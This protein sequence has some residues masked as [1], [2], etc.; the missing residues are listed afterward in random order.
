MTEI[1]AACVLFLAVVLFVIALVVI[2]FAAKLFMQ[3]VQQAHTARAHGAQA[4]ETQ[5]ATEQAETAVA[6]IKE[7]FLPLDNPAARPFDR[8]AD[9]ELREIILAGRHRNGRVT[10]DEEFTTEGNE[11][12]PETPP[13]FGGGMYREPQ[14]EFE[15]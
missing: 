9:N 13:I 10:H 12:I 11:G 1:I 5:Q 7:K 2:A 14:N 8:A 15:G 4:D 3:A 6:E